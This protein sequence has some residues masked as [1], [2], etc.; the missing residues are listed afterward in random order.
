MLFDNGSYRTA[1]NREYYAIFHA[2]RAVLVF[3]NY[4]SGKHSGIIGEFR[5]RYIKSGIFPVE[6]SKVIGL[7]FTIR[8]SSDYD[9]M[10]I[11]GRDETEEQIA[12]AEY[13]YKIVLEYINKKIGKLGDG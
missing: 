7:A 5:R 1:N 6:M 8:N 11:A 2:L 9:D 10:F 12:N 4:D 13:V 3:D